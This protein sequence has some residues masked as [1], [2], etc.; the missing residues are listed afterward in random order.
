M[1]KEPGTLIRKNFLLSKG[2][3]KTE[4]SHTETEAELRYY[5]P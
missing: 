1:T 2:Y 5:I 4:Y 3:G